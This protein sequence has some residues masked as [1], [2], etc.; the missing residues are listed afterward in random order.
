MKEEKQ[1]LDNN[2]LDAT[3]EDLS[4]TNKKSAY[5]V[6]VSLVAALGGFL[7]GFDTA[8]VSGAIVFLKKEFALNTV[9]T[10][11]AVSSILVGCVLGAM[12]AGVVCDRFGRK[13]TL[14]G[15]SALF[16][17]SS[18][19]AAL[20]TGLWD[21]TIARFVGG[22]GIGV[23]SMLSP[24]YIAEI[25]PPAARGRL[26]SL[27]QF[28]IVTGILAA[29]VVSWVLAE[30]ESAS[31]WRWMFGF[32]GIPSLLFM[33]ALLFVPESPRWLIQKARPKEALDVLEKFSHRAQAVKE[34]GEIEK[35]IAQERGSF[36]DLLE[37]RM[38]RPMVIAV[39]L[40]I[41]QQVTGINTILY[42]GSMI[43]TEQAAQSTSSAM[44]AN[45][46]I[47]GI[48]FIG[49]IAAM[50]VIDRI[51]RKPLLLVAAAGMT[52]SL[53]ALGFAFQAATP[54]PTLLLSLIMIYVA[55]FAV[56]L[57]PG[58]WVVMSELFPTRVRG[59]AM[60]VAT[61]ALWVACLGISFTFLSLVNAIGPSGAFWLYGA[62]SFITVGFIWFL[63]PET[64][65][66]T[67]EQI[68][69]SWK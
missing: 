48:N 59:R 6:L 2:L 38:R 3:T 8:V 30:G 23:A 61:I 29:Y 46:L 7:F 66:K 35:T 28:A 32:A 4:T 16:L 26:V 10:E 41:L 44:S 34:F 64:A 52:L 39:G 69:A 63:V 60:S 24:L 47:G 62:M 45:A 37:R 9:Q 42:Y 50:L 17:L 51:G 21:F 57:G 33:G 53:T 12:F 65:G 18:I 40:A 31:A 67:L 27:N 68:E 49:T 55:C 56:G 22:L 1:M 20:P 36:K 15:A 11:I 19:G 43:F 14:I 25:A 5:V 54:S 13:N 58:T